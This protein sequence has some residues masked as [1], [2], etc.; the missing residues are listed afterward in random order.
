MSLQHCYVFCVCVSHTHS[1]THGSC[2]L[3]SSVMPLATFCIQVYSYLNRHPAARF[4]HQIIQDT[5]MC[6]CI[7]G[8]QKERSSGKLWKSSFSKK[9]FHVHT[10]LVTEQRCTVIVKATQGTSTVHKLLFKLSICHPELLTVLDATHALPPLSLPPW[11]T[12]AQKWK[13]TQRQTDG[14]L[15]THRYGLRAHTYTQTHAGTRTEANT[16]TPPPHLGLKLT[17]N[18]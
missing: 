18:H 14:Q 5:Q 15:C 9:Y 3:P 4:P 11:H 2:P 16:R 12:Y 13:H 10:F 8:F 6:R 17:Y 1:Q 7:L